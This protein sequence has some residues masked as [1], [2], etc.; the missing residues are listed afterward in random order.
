MFLLHVLQAEAGN[1]EYAVQTM[2]ITSDTPRNYEAFGAPSIGHSHTPQG[3]PYGHLNAS[4]AGPDPMS[5][6]LG[7]LMQAPGVPP[8]RPGGNV[9]SGGPDSTPSQQP[10]F[11]SPPES[12]GA[13]YGVPPSSFTPPPH[14]MGPPHVSAVPAMPVLT[15]GS[16]APPPTIF[17]PFPGATSAVTTSVAAEASKF[18]PAMT[19]KEDVVTPTTPK[20]AIHRSTGSFSPPVSAPM[21]GFPPEVSIQ[22]FPGVAVQARPAAATTDSGRLPST[23]S[24]QGTGADDGITIS[25][26]TSTG[27][28]AVEL[29]TVESETPATPDVVA[30]ANLNRQPFS[31]VPIHVQQGRGAQNVVGEQPP[32][33][34]AEAV[35]VGAQSSAMMS[36]VDF[37]MAFQAQAAIFGAESSTSPKKAGFHLPPATHPSSAP[38]SGGGGVV[39]PPSRPPVSK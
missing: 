37:S 24:P 28:A 30:C 1:P 2:G 20:G 13:G 12:G 14:A 10:G 26:A 18:N 25:S 21:G 11:I 15:S 17:A 33:P 16:H 3:Q 31:G 29:F 22:S 27:P 9:Y 6:A 4:S 38:L 39:A 5:T 34:S 23:T 19:Q 8:P 36:T 35:G 32:Q 7:A